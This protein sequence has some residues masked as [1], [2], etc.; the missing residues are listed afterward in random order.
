MGRSIV[1]GSPNHNRK[2]GRRVSISFSAILRAAGAVGHE[3]LHRCHPVWRHGSRRGW[4]KG[5][6][7]GLLALMAAQLGA[8][9][10][11]AVELNREAYEEACSNFRNSPWNVHLQA[12]HADIRKYAATCNESFDLII[13]NPPFFQR[14]SKSSDDLRKLARHTDELAYPELLACAAKLLSDDGRL[15]LLLPV[16]V[17]A[18]IREEAGKSG[19]FLSR[20]INLKGYARNRAKVAALLFSR[21]ELKYEEKE[22]TIYRAEREYSKESERFLAPFLLRF[23]DAGK[24]VGRASARQ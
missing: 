5:T 14:H 4:G 8:G 15:Y 1:R 20:R 9:S 19:L 22:L 6:G 23:A 3:G 7:T 24:T 18:Q 21:T 17:V 10:V 16:M 12:V 2:A 13:S 11:T